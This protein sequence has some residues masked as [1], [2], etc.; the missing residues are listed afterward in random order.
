MKSSKLFTALAIL[1]LSASAFAQTVVTIATGP[2][3]G[4]YNT[5]QREATK[6]CNSPDLTFKVVNTTG[7]SVNMGQLIGNKVN[8]IWVQSDVL[9]L[10]SRSDDLSD[11][12]T[13]LAMHPEEIH[14]VVLSG[15]RPGKGLFSS[16]TPALTKFS[17]LKSTDKVGAAGGSF[18][19][20]RLILANAGVRFTIAPKFDDNKALLAALKA[21]T[22][23]VALIVGGAPLAAIAE[24]STEYK[25]LEMTEPVQKALVAT[26]GYKA[27][28]VSYDN[29]GQQ[30]VPTVTAE[31]LLVTRE[32]TLP[33]VVASLGTFRS[34]VHSSLPELRQTIG[35]HP[36]WRAVKAENKGRWAWYELPQAK[37]K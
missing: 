32:Y 10:A 31:A 2:A 27:A 35:N 29:L 14:P 1:A 33:K 9:V 8:A 22:I 25:L 24:L 19:T 4:T 23:D 20:A 6:V 5:M 26:G 18:D 17:E 15:P 13:L 36:K 30:G 28:K 3:D 11:V 12:K 21:G 16:A 34:C 7:S 37:S